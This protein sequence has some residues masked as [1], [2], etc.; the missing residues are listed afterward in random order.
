MALCLRKD[1]IS[2][3]MS[4]LR[5]FN[6]VLKQNQNAITTNPQLPQLGFLLLHDATDNSQLPQLFDYFKRITIEIPFLNPKKTLK[7]VQGDDLYYCLEERAKPH[8]TVM[9][10]SFQHLFPLKTKTSILTNPPS[11]SFVHPPRTLW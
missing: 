1:T 6:S 8:F 5:D 10:N 3:I 2:T 7:Q 9:L 11:V 4:F